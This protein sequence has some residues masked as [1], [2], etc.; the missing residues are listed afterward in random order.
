MIFWFN[1]LYV[2]LVWCSSYSCHEYCFILLFGLYIN[3]YAE[4]LL[5][6]AKIWIPCHIYGLD[7]VIRHSNSFLSV[8]IATPRASRPQLGFTERPSSRGSTQT[9][10]P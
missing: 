10:N 3:L 4:Q 5:C 6:Y 7:G 9:R 1:L 8:I 2:Q